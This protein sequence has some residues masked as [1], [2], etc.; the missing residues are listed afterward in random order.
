MFKAIKRGGR[1]LAALLLALM[2]LG[3]ELTPALAVTQSD[4]NALKDDASDL[5][6]Q[7]KELQAKL[8]QLA[9]DKSAAMERRSGVLRSSATPVHDRKA[10]GMHSTMP[11]LFSIR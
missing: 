7:K 2:L 6:S 4:I 11:L 1:I 10:V 9:D 3:G 8:D 5:N